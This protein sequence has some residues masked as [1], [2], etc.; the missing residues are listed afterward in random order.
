MK[1]LRKLKLNEMQDFTAIEKDEAKSLKG[2]WLL[3]SDTWMT[4]LIQRDGYRGGG[5]VAYIGSMTYGSKN[6]YAGVTL[7]M[8]EYGYSVTHH[9]GS[10]AGSITPSNA[11]NSNVMWTKDSYYNTWKSD[12]IGTDVY[13]SG[14]AAGGIM[15]TTTGSWT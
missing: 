2:G 15:P 9:M 11:R 14:V 10:T 8:S 1:K 3:D 6:Y 13:N 5:A 12:V 4:V 7:N